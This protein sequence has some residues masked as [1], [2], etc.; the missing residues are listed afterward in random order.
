MSSVSSI[1]NI[2]RPKGGSEQYIET[3]KLEKQILNLLFDHNTLFVEHLIVFNQLRQ[4]INENRC[5]SVSLSY[6][7]AL[8]FR[9]LRLS[10]E[11]SNR[12]QNIFASLKNIAE[13][14]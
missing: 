14:I 4:I 8:L 10:D 9:L 2:Q 12:K 5:C 1:A 3:F 11:D 13:N 6:I 7:H